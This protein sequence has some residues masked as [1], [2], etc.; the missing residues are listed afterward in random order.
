[1]RVSIRFLGVGVLVLIAAAI[2]TLLPS[3]AAAQPE[4]EFPDEAPYAPGEWNIGR[5]VDESQFRYCVD[6]RDPAWQQDGEIADAIAHGL[7]LQPTRYVTPGEFVVED[8]TRLYAILLEHCDV[9]MGFKLIPGGYPAWVTLTRPYSEV[10][11][12]FVT[13]RLD[14]RALAD[15]PPGRPI[16]ATRGTTAHIRLASYNIALPANQRWPIFPY[17]TDQLSLESV[18]S[19]TADLA[20][21]WEPSFRDMQRQNPAYAAFRIIAPTPLPPTTLGV[22]GLLLR[23]NTFL[24]AAIDQAIAALTADGTIPAILNKYKSPATG[25]P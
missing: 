24:R 10:G 15:L 23:Q 14:I 3:T 8:L 1:V 16:A 17:G 13:A 21:V 20:L 6:P 19:N 18:L 4:P 25:K 5:R 9:Y 11:Y 22:G 7:L 12:V 2:A